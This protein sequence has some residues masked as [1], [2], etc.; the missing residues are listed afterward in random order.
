MSSAARRAVAEAQI[1][2]LVGRRAPVA[3]AIAVAQVSA[4]LAVSESLDSVA[5]ALAGIR[6]DLDLIRQHL[7]QEEAASAPQD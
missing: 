2:E 3:D 1:S 6:A 5:G 4:I 7:L